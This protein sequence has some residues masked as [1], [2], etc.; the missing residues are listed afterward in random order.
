MDNDVAQI[1]QRPVRPG[2]ALDPASAHALLLDAF[3]QMPGDGAHVTVGPAADND[4]EIGDQGLALEVY[5][6]KVFRLVV[7]Q[8]VDNEVQELPD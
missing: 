6:D 8:G 1:G 5:G 2:Q 7:F 3:R 4:H